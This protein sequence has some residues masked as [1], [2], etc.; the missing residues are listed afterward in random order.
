[1]AWIEKRRQQYR[2]YERT[3]TGP[4]VYEAFA[5]RDD[6]ESF[7]ELA[8]GSGGSEPSTM[9]A[10]PCRSPGRRRPP[11]PARP[12]LWRRVDKAH[13]RLRSVTPPRSDP[14]QRGHAGRCLAVAARSYTRA[15][16]SA[17]ESA[18]CVHSPSG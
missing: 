11:T 4:K 18:S 16:T 5:S 12:M 3:V 6:A 8:A 9:S 13:G 1:M 7:K 10:N 17:G 15:L 14:C 2:V